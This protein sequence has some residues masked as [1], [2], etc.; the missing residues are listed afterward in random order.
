MN[1]RQDLIKAEAEIKELKE[2]V[3]G[4]SRYLVEIR[5]QLRNDMRADI[6]TGRPDWFGVRGTTIA[7][8]L[9]AEVG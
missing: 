1:A 8:I 7:R 6:G 3:A 2:T 5:E 4:Q 9:G